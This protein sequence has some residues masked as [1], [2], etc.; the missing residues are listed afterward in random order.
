MSN[1]AVSPGTMKK[2]IGYRFRRKELLRT[3]LTHPSCGEGF[4]NYER[5]EFLGDTILASVLAEELYRRYPNKSEGDLSMY[6]TALTN[7]R[8]LAELAKELQIVPL[9]K[10]QGVANAQ[11]RD[12][13]HENALE[14]IVGAIFLDS[15]Y[16]KVRKVVVR[17][18]EPFDKRL[19]KELKRSNPKGRIQELICSLRP[20]AVLDYRLIAETGEDHE[21]VYSVALYCE[22]ELLGI[23]SGSSM[24]V[25]EKNAAFHALEVIFQRAKLQI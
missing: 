23:G 22:K 10:V 20:S 6:K 24:K 21:R 14:A 4:A 13:I 8:F 12:S 1:D 18:Y 19:E 16:G 9:I 15:R 5:L 25:A 11:Q 3:A 2:L 7:G 17:W